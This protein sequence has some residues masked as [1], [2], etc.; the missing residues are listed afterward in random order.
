MRPDVPGPASSARM[1]L[2]PRVPQK[3]CIRA[4]RVTPRSP[5]LWAPTLEGTVPPPSPT[6]QTGLCPRCCR[7]GPAWVRPRFGAPSLQSDLSAGRTPPECS[8]ALHGTLAFEGVPHAPAAVRRGPALR[9]RLLGAWAQPSLLPVIAHKA[10]PCGALPRTDRKQ[11]RYKVGGQG[12]KVGL[13]PVHPEQGPGR[14][15]FFSITLPTILLPLSPRLLQDSTH[16]PI[17]LRSGS[18]SAF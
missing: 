18:F 10:H 8:K 14:H 12:S 17:C 15:P 4:F 11:K 1:T 13:R 7:T 16:P 5:H 3:L 2:A 6:L 9:A